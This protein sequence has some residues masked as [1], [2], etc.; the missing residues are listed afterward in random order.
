MALE[1]GHEVTVFHRG[2]GEDPWPRAEHVHGD[3]EGGLGALA[4]RSFDVIVDF[5]AYV[6][7]QIGEAIAALPD[8]RYVFI[9]SV[10][11]HVE[12]ARAGATEVDDVYEPPF[13]DTEEVTWETYGPLKVACE[14]TL[15]AARGDRATIVRPHYI[16]GPHDPTDRFTYWVRRASIGGRMLAPAPADQPLQW[17]DA[18]DL[19]A[20]ILHVGTNDMAG[21]FNVAVPPERHTLG[22][23]IETSAET[24]GSSVEVAWCDEPFVAS[25]GLLVTEDNDPFP[26]L[27]PDEPNAHLFDTSNAVAHGL[28]FRTLE[29]TVAD[30]L[31]WDRE[32][33]LP[34]LKA[35]LAAQ[36]EAEL[37][38]AW[39]A[40]A[41][42]SDR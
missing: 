1:A 14:T 36:R 21:T 13:P 33:G 20:F 4:G 22:E 26:L 39:E 11:A 27:T 7:R 18:R 28:R 19:A 2:R 42:P 6:P 37:L 23:L 9:S 8:G 32:R 15:L 16:V 25:N 5:C 29:E 31:A 12:H 40:R 41:D 35:G 10:S 30:T 17:I 34:E 3:R 24:A 38:A